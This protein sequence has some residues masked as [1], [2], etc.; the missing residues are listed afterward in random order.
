MKP[1]SFVAVE[2]PE[3]PTTLLIAAT[4]VAWKAAVIQPRV[5]PSLIAFL[6]P[7]AV[8]VILNV[9]VFVDALPSLSVDV[10]T[11]VCE[12]AV[13]VSMSIEPEVIVVGA[14]CGA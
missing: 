2:P 9:S 4:S 10:I 7:T 12:P 14:A 6:I 3:A 1:R 5:A 13:S 11:M 8:G